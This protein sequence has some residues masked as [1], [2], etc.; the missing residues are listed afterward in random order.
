VST[1]ASEGSVRVRTLTR[2]DVPRIMEIENEAFSTPWRDMTFYGLLRRTDTDMIGAECD[3][4]LAGYAIAWT[5]ID[6]AEIGNVAVDRQLRAR[7][8]GRIL[9][10]S[11]VARL[12]ERGVT[13]CFLEVRESNTVAQSLYD[14]CGF[15]VV[16]RRRGYYK[17]PVEDALV[18]RMRLKETA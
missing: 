3:G 8:V 2:A 15:E 12:R 14:S 10:E 11:I 5:V 13:E 4:R 9:V 7:G 1:P 6:Q 16:G 18:M 17:E